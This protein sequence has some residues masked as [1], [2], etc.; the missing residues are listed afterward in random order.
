MNLKP[1]VTEKAVMLI[2]KENVL[3]FETEKHVKKDDA[4]K[5]IESIFSVKVE[6]IRT[7]IKENK[8]YLYVKLKKEFHALDVATKLGVI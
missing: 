4:K 8:K 5:E 2:E 7:L 1:V 6:K 3:T